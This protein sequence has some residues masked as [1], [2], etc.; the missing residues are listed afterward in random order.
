MEDSTDPL[1]AITVYVV[2]DAPTGNKKNLFFS[3]FLKEKGPKKRPFFIT[4][5]SI[6]T[7]YT[8]MR[9]MINPNMHNIL[10]KRVGY[11]ALS[12]E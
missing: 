11:L 3:P 6:I 2:I 4:H 1:S 9:R 7:T 10:S 12:S 5:R 8:V